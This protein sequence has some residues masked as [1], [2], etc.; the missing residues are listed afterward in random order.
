MFIPY[1][2][3]VFFKDASETDALDNRKSPANTASCN[4]KPKDFSTLDRLYCIYINS[5][6]FLV[7]LSL[8]FPSQNWVTQCPFLSLH[9]PIHHHEEDLQPATA[10]L[11]LNYSYKNRRKIEFW[12]REFLT[13]IISVISAI[14]CCLNC[15]SCNVDSDMPM[16]GSTIVIDDAMS[17]KIWNKYKKVEYGSTRSYCNNQVIWGSPNPH[18]HWA[19]NYNDPLVQKW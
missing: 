13:W 12:W 5:K 3:S 10:M 8:C 15:C 14:L 19:L 18:K 2:T 4:E 6:W 9:C 1:L 17:S 11:V 16:S 7:N